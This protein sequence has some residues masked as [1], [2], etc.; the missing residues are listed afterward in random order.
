ML[1]AHDLLKKLKSHSK[2]PGARDGEV[3]HLGR[4]KGWWPAL[5]A[6]WC[7]LALGPGSLAADGAFQGPELRTEEESRV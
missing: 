2:K 6:S 3:T 7:A 1:K 5:P 4:V